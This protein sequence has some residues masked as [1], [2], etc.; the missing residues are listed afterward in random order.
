MFVAL[1]VIPVPCPTFNARVVVMDPPPVKPDP[2]V[3]LTL[4]WSICSFATKPVVSS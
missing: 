1:T 2:A 4:E 3:I